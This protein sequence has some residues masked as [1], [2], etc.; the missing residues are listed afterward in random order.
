MGIVKEIKSPAIRKL[1]SDLFL[2]PQEK[3]GDFSQALLGEGIG[4]SS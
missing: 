1:T 4:S 3:I 2:T